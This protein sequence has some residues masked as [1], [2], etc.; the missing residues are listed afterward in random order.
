MH[1]THIGDFFLLSFFILLTILLQMVEFFSYYFLSGLPLSP[2]IITTHTHTH[3]HTTTHNHTQPHTHTHTVKP[4]VKGIWQLHPLVQLCGEGESFV[5]GLAVLSAPHGGQLGHGAVRQWVQRQGEGQ[6]CSVLRVDVP[7]R[8]GGGESVWR[9]T[10][11]FKQIDSEFQVSI[12][13]SHMH[14][15]N[16][17]RH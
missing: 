1:R 13:I 14:N 10:Q 4:P 6:A 12:C 5:G 8:A 3:T 16:S 9:P 11:S 7:G 15:N 2:F 17:G